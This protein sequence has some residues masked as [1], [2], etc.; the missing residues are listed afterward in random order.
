MQQ[1]SHTLTEKKIWE[2]DRIDQNWGFFAPVVE[3]FDGIVVI[4][5]DES[6]SIGLSNGSF[7]PSENCSNRL[8]PWCRL[9]QLPR[10]ELW[11]GSVAFPSSSNVFNRRACPRRN[12]E[13]VGEKEFHSLTKISQTNETT[14]DHCKK[15]GNRESSH[16]H[17]RDAEV[18][19]LKSTWFTECLVRKV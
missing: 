11:L 4:S 15:N 7:S 18:L 16:Y 14:D 19:V 17:Q 5:S 2:W 1:S 12:S 10:N 3:G 6:S 9:S 8:K 13:S